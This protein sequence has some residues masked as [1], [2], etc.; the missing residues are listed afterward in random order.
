[1]KKVISL[2]LAVIMLAC[3]AINAGAASAEYEKLQFNNDGSFRIMQISDIQ[4]GPFLLDITRDY[5]DAVIPYANPDLI[6]LSGDNIAARSYS[7]GVKEID[8]VLAKIAID[9]FMSIIE[10]Y[11]IP[12]AVVFGN[13]DAEKLVT[14]E[15]QMEMYLKYDNCIAIDEGEALY[16]CGTYNLPIY[17]SA[18]VNKIAYNIWMFDSNMYDKENGGYDHVHQDQIDWYIGKSN[19][20]KAQNGG[21]PV[22]SMVFQHIVVNE[23]FDAFL[24]VPAGTEG[25]V[26]KDGKYY[27]LNPENTRA[28]EL[29]EAPCPGTVDSQ[30]FEAMVAQGD[31]EAM[32]FGHDHVNS[33]EIEYNGIDL[34]NTPGVG[35]N[36]YG[37]DNRGVRIIDLKEGVDGYTT[38]LI[39]YK[40]FYGDDDA[41]NARFTLYGSEFETAEKISAFFEYIFFSVLKIFSF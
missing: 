2:V 33:F 13:H 17:S 38:E 39:T 28:G 22:P 3:V 32:F 37:G 34:V 27:V 23:V 14:K 31:V 35:F 8:L 1:M 11:D 29:N 36:S 15:E 41:A 18:D 12:V 30:Q 5:L 4:D 20:L 7:I 26:E 6:V 21:N 10:D 16:G 25:A 40:D 9:R 19:E 24:E